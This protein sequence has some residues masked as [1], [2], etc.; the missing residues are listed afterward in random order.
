MTA[1]T[2]NSVV[3]CFIVRFRS[4]SEIDNVWWRLYTSLCK[5]NEWRKQ[6]GQK[7]V[8]FG[9]ICPKKTTCH[10]RTGAG[11]SPKSFYLLHK[12][13]EITLAPE[14]SRIFISFYTINHFNIHSTS[15]IFSIQDEGVW[16]TLNLGLA[17]VILNAKDLIQY[18]RIGNGFRWKSPTSRELVAVTKTRFFGQSF[19]RIPQK[20]PN[21][22]KNKGAGFF[23]CGAQKVDTS[24]YELSDLDGIEV[25][26]QN[27]QLEVDAVLD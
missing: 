20:T 7:S 14:N 8:S 23:Y 12:G 6:I 10:N 1:T 15:L 24:T 3:T 9:K 2:A 22:Q 21:K 18:T 11:N 25:F 5:I 26:W 17:S 13:L 27:P 16:W 19:S 4:T